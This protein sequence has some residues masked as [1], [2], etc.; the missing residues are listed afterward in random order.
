[1][2]KLV[3]LLLL[4]GC[5]SPAITPHVAVAPSAA[6]ASRQTQITSWNLEQALKPH[7]VYSHRTLLILSAKGIWIIAHRKHT[8][9]VN[10]S[11]NLTIYKNGRAEGCVIQGTKTAYVSEAVIGLFTN[12]NAT[13]C[14]AAIAHFKGQTYAREILPLKFF[15]TGNC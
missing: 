3:L 14:L 13:G 7:A 15:A 6:T 5:A 4:T 2:R 9:I 8:A 12:Y 1:M 10:G 11:C